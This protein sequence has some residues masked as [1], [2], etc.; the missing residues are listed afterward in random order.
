ML[1]EECMS[2]FRMAL[3]CLCSTIAAAAL[4]AFAPSIAPAQVAGRPI[5]IIVP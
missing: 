4:F 5:T 3:D 2:I 1:D